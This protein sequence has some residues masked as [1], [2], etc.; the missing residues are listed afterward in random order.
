MSKDLNIVA[1]I[2]RLTRDGE[3]KTT[4]NGNSVISFTLAV[5]DDYGE[6]KQ[7]YFFD[8]Q[9]WTKANINQYLLKG[10][11]IAIEGSLQQQKW[12]D[13]NGQN[14]SKIVINVKSLQFLTKSNNN[15]QGN[16]QDNGQQQGFFPEKQQ[17]FNDEP[18]SNPS[19]DDM[20]F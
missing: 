3:L 14:K 9:Y 8:C 10:S 15:Q 18:W 17:N 13:Q 19:F 20:P 11:Q 2:G 5:G 12:T 1:I 7:S 16:Q 6:K 4:Q